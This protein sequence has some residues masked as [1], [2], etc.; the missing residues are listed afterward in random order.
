[1]AK[2]NWFFRAAS[3]SASKIKEGLNKGAA[4]LFGGVTKGT[5][6]AIAGLG[7]IFALPL[8]LAKRGKDKMEAA[9]SPEKKGTG[10]WLADIGRFI[11]WLLKLLINPASI[12]IAI[13]LLF[14]IYTP[15][16]AGFTKIGSA[17]PSFFSGL[18]NAYAQA[19]KLIACGL[20]NECPT[21]GTARD[22]TKYGIYFDSIYTGRNG[23]KFYKD[24][25]IRVTAS[26]NAETLTS[27]D[28]SGCAKVSCEI[29]DGSVVSKNY[30]CISLKRGFPAKVIC[31]YAPIVSDTGNEKKAT[32]KLTYDFQASTKIPISIVDSSDYD[33]L[34]NDYKEQTS[35]VSELEGRIAEHYGVVQNPA[36]DPKLTPL[37]IGAKIEKSQ[38]IPKGTDDV[39]LQVSV[40][41]EGGGTASIKD[42]SL[43]LPP[44]MTLLRSE[45]I[46]LDVPNPIEWTTDM[47][48]KY[49][50][51][52]DQLSS[53]K[54]NLVAGDFR[55]YDIKLG[56][57]GFPLT[58]STEATTK[59]I[60]IYV[61][62]TYT[63]TTNKIVVVQTC[64]EI[65]GCGTAVADSDT[66]VSVS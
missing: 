52:S 10:F 42:I 61:D 45:E 6:Y 24:E 20:M 63:S 65:G 44:G 31:T 13:L 48:D 53:L 41:N 40:Q 59:N 17:A 19:Q 28:L 43:E 56:T 3:S 60:V 8:V 30:D 26:A 2:D 21:T 5:K 23:D 12:I 27:M 9:G 57:S 49:V 16:Q 34:W 25:N 58:S 55:V 39:W 66:P 35:T 32:I 37:V 4:G 1:M 51:K 38:P 64:S 22:L 11:G 50:L 54:D 36:S 7:A 15:V 33:S 47:V 14:L 18:G 62:Y 29:E 46:N